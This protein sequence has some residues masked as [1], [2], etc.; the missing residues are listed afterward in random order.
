MLICFEDDQAAQISKGTI[1]E[2]YDGVGIY[3][4]YST[5]FTHILGKLGFYNGQPTTVGSTGKDGYRKT[6]TFDSDGWF[7]LPD[8]P[9]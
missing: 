2:I 1:C 9:K 7:S 4:S 8:H 3:S 5:N 6:E